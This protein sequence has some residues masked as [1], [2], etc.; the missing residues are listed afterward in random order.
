MTTD[1]TELARNALIEELEQLRDYMT[2]V[3]VQL[4]QPVG[5]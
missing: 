1:F 4:I 5:K 2:N 3:V